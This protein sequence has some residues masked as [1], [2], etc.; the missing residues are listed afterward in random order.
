MRTSTGLR[1]DQYWSLISTTTASRCDQYWSDE[2]PVLVT[3]P[4][5]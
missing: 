4:A 1:S 2:W 5:S 3:F